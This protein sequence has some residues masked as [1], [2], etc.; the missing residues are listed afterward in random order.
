MTSTLAPRDSPT[1]SAMTRAEASSDFPERTLPLSSTTNRG[2][3]SI[4]LEASFT[5]SISSTSPFVTLCCFPPA[6]MTAYIWTS[7]NLDRRDRIAEH[8]RDAELSARLG[9]VVDQDPPPLALV[10]RVRE[11]L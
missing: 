11:R 9:E 2:V 8:A 6:R 5:Y 7:L 4:G 10:T 1:T 3:N